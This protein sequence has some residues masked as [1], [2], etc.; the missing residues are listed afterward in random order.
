M[1]RNL[2]GREFDFMNYTGNTVFVCEQ[3]WR[4]DNGTVFMR[5]KFKFSFYTDLL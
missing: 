4:Q 2:R 1:T 3:K 5:C